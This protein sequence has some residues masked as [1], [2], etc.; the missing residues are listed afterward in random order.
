MLRL[1]ADENFDNDVVR[2]LLRR[3]P[4]LD[5]VRV[6]DTGL[7]GSRDNEILAWA[8]KENRV[9]LTH[10]VSTM[11]QFAHQRIAQHNSMPGLIL[12]A[13]MPDLGRI[14]EDILLICE[15]CET[16]ELENRIIHLPL[17]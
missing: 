13:Q 3:N 14:I 2:G 6:Q 10:D 12:I 9:V 17:R 15:C 8:A 11:S 7:M 5:I 1:A 4:T 16:S